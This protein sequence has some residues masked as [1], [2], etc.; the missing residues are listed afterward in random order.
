M[1]RWYL[2]AFYDDGSPMGSHRD[3]ECRIDSLTTELCCIF[4]DAGPRAGEYRADQLSAAELV[5]EK[6]S[7]DPAVHSAV[8]PF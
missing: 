7:A 3:E 5:D 1:G 4:T 2:R 8:R 6:T